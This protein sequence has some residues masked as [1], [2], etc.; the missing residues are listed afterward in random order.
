[1]DPITYE[2]ALEITLPGGEAATV[3]RF[4]GASYVLADGR[5]FLLPDTAAGPDETVAGVAAHIEDALAVDP[6]PARRAELR[7]VAK[8]RRAELLAA[9]FVFLGKL[10]QTRDQVDISNINSAALTA[11]VDPAYTTGW[12]CADNSVLPLDAAGVIAMQRAM[13]EA[14]NAIFAAFVETTA[15]LETATTLAELEALAPGMETFAP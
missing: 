4:D 11:S 12:I 6:L 3:T 13:V 14:G 8:A 15:P 10:I 9:G 2:P 7:N 5:T 1:M